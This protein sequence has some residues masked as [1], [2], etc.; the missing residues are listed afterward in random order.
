M[1]TWRLT[2]VLL[3]IVLNHGLVFPHIWCVEIYYPWTLTFTN[4]RSKVW[5]IEQLQIIIA[6]LLNLRCLMRHPILRRPLGTL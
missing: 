6:A 1:I 2:I 5:I 4:S 3:Q